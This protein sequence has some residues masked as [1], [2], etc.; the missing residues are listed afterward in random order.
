MDLEAIARTIRVIAL[1]GK[2]NFGR[3]EV[4]DAFSN[5]F[6]MLT[7]RI[8]AVWKLEAASAWYITFDDSKIVD[9]LMQ[10]DHFQGSGDRV[11]GITS[12]DQLHENIVQPSI[13]PVL[14]RFTT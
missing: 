8:Q 6:R 7:E 13:F 1:S 4:M 9:D 11:F 14:V 2:K 5:E 10:F 3:A 12:C